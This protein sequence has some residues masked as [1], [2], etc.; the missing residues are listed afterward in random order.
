MAITV[1]V[2]R[3][4]AAL[5]SYADISARRSAAASSA[6]GSAS[7]SAYAAN[8]RYATARQQMRHQAEQAFF[9][10][11]HQA[12]AQL[13]RQE[14]LAQQADLD[15]GQAAEMQD[16]RIDSAERM[17][18]MRANGSTQLPRSGGYRRG[19]GGAGPMMFHPMGGY[20]RALAETRDQAF[21]SY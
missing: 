4:T 19:G 20:R 1:G 14:F 13:E 5:P 3:L 12:G 21:G 16:D 6:G 10:R 7:S 17:Q 11:Q 9:D 15:R 18:A 2:G 8:R